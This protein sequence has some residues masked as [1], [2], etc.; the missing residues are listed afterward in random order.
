[1]ISFGPDE[2]MHLARLEV[3]YEHLRRDADEASGL[4]SHITALFADWLG[5]IIAKL[6][7]DWTS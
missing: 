1:M 7:T 2:D 4:P 3:M 6:H 5:E